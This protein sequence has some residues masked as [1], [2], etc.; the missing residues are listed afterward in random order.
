MKV[1]TGTAKKE[2]ACKHQDCRK[3][4]TKGQKYYL[5]HLK[6]DALRQHQDHGQPTVKSTVKAATKKKATKKT[7]LRKKKLGRKRRVTK[8]TKR[9]GK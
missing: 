6:G 9:G 1:E 4:I 5:W 2:W 8:T 3:K 7:V